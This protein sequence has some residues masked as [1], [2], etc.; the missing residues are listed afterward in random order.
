MLD[1]LG[2][3]YPQTAVLFTSVIVDL[4]GDDD[5][6]AGFREGDTPGDVVLG[7]F[8]LV[9]SMVITSEI[10]SHSVSGCDLRPLYDN[11]SIGVRYS[12]E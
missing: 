10:C 9:H 3:R 7:F 5:L 2:L 12:E 8:H 1:F 4:L 11:K 6:A